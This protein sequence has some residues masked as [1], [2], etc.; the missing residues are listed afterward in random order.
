M[1]S[2]GT[3]YGRT[4][5]AP[6]PLALRQW[7]HDVSEALPKHTIIVSSPLQRCLLASRGLSAHG[8]S[9]PLIDER[10]AE[11]DFGFWEGKAWSHID[12]QELRSW[13]EQRLIYQVPGGES[14]NDL[15]NR[16]VSALTHWQSQ[17]KAD[18]SRPLAL[19]THAGVMQVLQAHVNDGDFRHWATRMKN[20]PAGAKPAAPLPYGAILKLA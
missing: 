15:G 16:T 1:V 13:R 7:W 11:F 17:A 2:E 18:S 14:V 8:F 6:D 10:I 9:T 20:T 3:C 12:G 5:L 19:V 4:D